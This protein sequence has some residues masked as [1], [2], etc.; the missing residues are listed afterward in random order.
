MKEVKCRNCGHWNPADKEICE[1]C[2][3]PL[4][5]E[6]Y[7][8]KENDP[9]QREVKLPLWQLKDSDNPLLRGT[10]HTVRFGQLIFFTIISFIAA[11]A[12]STVH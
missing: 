12:S 7:Q 4:R 10:K 2:K 11:M 3:R 6:K 8:P 1:E 9:R 5:E